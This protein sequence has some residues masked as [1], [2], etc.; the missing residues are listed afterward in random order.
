MLGNWLVH[1]QDLHLCGEEEKDIFPV[2]SQSFIK[3][4]KVLLRT[5]LV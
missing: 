2:Q 5:F 4:E 3:Y 1:L